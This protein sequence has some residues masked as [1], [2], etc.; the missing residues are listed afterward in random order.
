MAD[1]GLYSA[2]RGTDDWQTKRQDKKMNLLAAEK[3]NQMQQQK[4]AE[5]AAA[6]ADVA[7]Y[8][9]ELQNLEVLPEDQE[10]VSQAEKQ[11]RQKIVAGIAANNGDLRKYMSSGGVTALSQY[12]TNVMQSE[13]VKQAGV[14]KVN[15]QNYLTQD[16][17]GNQRHR[18]VD[19]T[20]PV[21]R[22]GQQVVDENGQP[23]TE[24][25]KMSWQD[26]YALYKEGKIKQLNYNGSETRIKL[27][28]EDFSKY[29]KN[30][31]DPY[32]EDNYVTESNI[33]EKMLSEGAS[34]EYAREQAKKY[35]EMHKQGGDAWRW[36]AG[37]P[38][39]LA[40][41][42]ARLKA[43]QQKASGGGSDDRYNKTATLHMM[44]NIKALGHGNEMKMGLKD[45]PVFIRQ[46]GLKR[47]DETGAMIDTKGL[48]AID[49]GEYGM[50]DGTRSEL[51]L[52]LAEDIQPLGYVA[53]NDKNGNKKYYVKAMASFDDPAQGGSAWNPLDWFE[54]QREG[55]PTSQYGP[56]A[57]YNE[58][59]WKYNGEKGTVDGEVLI[60]IQDEMEESYLYSQIDKEINMNA[61]MH[62]PPGSPTHEDYMNEISQY[63]ERGLAA[64]MTAEEIDQA[65]M[66]LKNE[67]D[68]DNANLGK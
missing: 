42:A 47:D 56:F 51:D 22:D 34:E 25:K 17:K 49:A 18:M 43:A 35:G 45:R 39:E 12:K 55:A 10:R 11:A 60:P 68:Y 3:Q 66:D 13:A 30:P 65:W 58:N 1:W 4:V 14:N 26:Q 31:A 52:S 6:E 64:G 9:E 20:L 33:Y 54:G 40:L 44:G 46:L 41:K 16:A 62:A 48:K 53:I 37:D 36:N 29:Y 38:Y 15:L 50:G 28:I 24:T 21:M 27:G 32:Q 19:V 8:M 7:K 5:S 2:L 61:N 23:L 63:Y 59:F 57:G 67:V